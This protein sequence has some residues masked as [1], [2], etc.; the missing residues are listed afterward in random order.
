MAD[1]I[2][3]VEAAK[4]SIFAVYS[5]DTGSDGLNNSSS[6]AR[7]THFVDDDDPD[8]GSDRDLHPSSVFVTVTEDDDAV[9]GATG[10]RRVVLTIT[11]RVRTERDG[12]KGTVSITK[13]GAINSRLMTKFDGQ[14]LATQS[15]WSFSPML[16]VGGGPRKA[17][18]WYL[19]Y[20]HTFNV[21]ATG[22]A[23]G[24]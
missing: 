14:I 15:P 9:F 6:G 12:A 5:A 7:V 17:N 18:G 13:Q 11:M 23:T 19:A 8:Y 24:S 3:V 16:R 2:D 4:T 21:R 20:D 22:P 10:T 1:V